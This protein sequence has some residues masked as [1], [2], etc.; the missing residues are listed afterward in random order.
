MD[1]Q[2]FESKNLTATNIDKI[3]EIFPGVVTEGKSKFRPVRGARR[4]GKEKEKR[5]YN[6]QF[7]C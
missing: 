6:P 3:A 2:R 5:N 4:H 1:K 7:R